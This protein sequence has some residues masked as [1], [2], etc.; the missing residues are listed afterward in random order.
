E[1]IR[2]AYQGALVAQVHRGNQVAD[3]AVILD[4]ASRRQPEGIASLMLKNGQGL[5]MPLKEVAEVYLTTGRY[6]IM[7]DGAS[8]R[9]IVTCRP[10]GRDVTSLV[11]AAKKQIAAKVTFPKGVYAVFTGTAEATAKARQ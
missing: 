1:A 10:E 2:S 5:S 11:A 7:H 3:V 9:Q 4:E 6:S 8:R